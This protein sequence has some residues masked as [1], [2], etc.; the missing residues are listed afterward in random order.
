MQGGIARK[1]VGK[2]VGKFEQTL[3]IQHNNNE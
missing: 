3:T 1:D 2:H